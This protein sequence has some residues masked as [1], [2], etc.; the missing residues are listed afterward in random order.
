MSYTF[1][2]YV[3][4]SCIEKIKMQ[5]VPPSCDFLMHFF[6]KN[7]CTCMQPWCKFSIHS[8][9]SRL[10]VISCFLSL[11]FSRRRHGWIS[12]LRG[13]QFFRISSPN[14]FIFLIAFQSGPRNSN[15]GAMVMECEVGKLYARMRDTVSAATSSPLLISPSASDDD[16]LCALK[17][18]THVLSSNS[19][20]Y[21]VCPVSSFHQITGWK[22][23]SPD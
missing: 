2:G 11:C 23:L 21:S 19:I 1:H 4:L 3:L 10:F 7:T 9:L 16:S 13:P 15:R 18:I 12:H 5:W 14:P 6:F 17:I 22:F 20:R 8:F